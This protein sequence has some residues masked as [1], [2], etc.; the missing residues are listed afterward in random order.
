MLKHYLTKQLSLVLQLLML[1]ACSSFATIVLWNSQFTVSAN[2]T[3]DWRRSGL[4]GIGITSI[5][6]DVNNT[7]YL[8]AASRD[9]IGV[10]ISSNSGESWTN[11]DE[12]LTN[13]NI[14]T[15]ASCTSGWL[16]AGS[17]GDGVYRRTSNT[18]WSRVSNGVTE[19]FITALS[20]GANSTVFVAT[21][22]QGVFRSTNHGESW[23]SISQGLGQLEILSLYYADGWLLVGTK[24]GLFAQQ[25]SSSGWQLI[26][27]ADRT[28]YALFTTNDY[29]WAGTDQGVYRTPLANLMNWA[30][31]GVLPQ[32]V[33]AL[34]ADSDTSLYAGTRDAGVYQ[35]SSEEWQP[36]NTNLLVTRIYALRLGTDETSKLFAGTIDGI[37][38][39]QVQR[40]P[41]P[42]AP[43]T[44]NQTPTSTP[45]PTPT[46]TPG[47][48]YLRLRSEPTGVIA[49]GETLT[50]II[51]YGAIE[52]ATTGYELQSV[53]ITNVIPAAVNL[54]PASLPT[55]SPQ[56]LVTTT[57]DKAGSVITWT[58]L[59]PVPDGAHGAISYQVQR[60]TVTP[61]LMPTAPS[62]P[63]ALQ[64][65]KSGPAMA[66]PDAFIV[67]TLS[68]TNPS[69]MIAT[70]VIMTDR[71]PL[72]AQYVT[73]G[74]REGEIVKWMDIGNLAPAEPVSRVFVVTAAQTITNSDYGVQADGIPVITGTK[75][76]VTIIGNSVTS[77]GATNLIINQGASM[78]WLYNGQTGRITSG[79]TY[80]PVTIL[81]LP[82]MAKAK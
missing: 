38:S 74:V 47:I 63:K 69:N 53:V 31:I 16:F 18:P 46:S 67:Y 10:R 14:E 76:I 32:I 36:F 39:S 17:W 5:I 25:D 71:I 33:Y 52:H 40:T 55:N 15:I 79:P 59:T 26:G 41:T 82:F 3:E 23:Q 4:N 20:C 66:T 43:P 50:Y 27:L 70:N 65:T 73:G 28:I 9:V 21:A 81:Y 6:N 58:F 29:W 44:V 62:Q 37:W 22:S 49:Y 77:P 30:S 2:G 72:H 54:I 60:P 80:N 68:V 24:Q 51:E 8:Y 78:R 11:Y 75:S 19:Q 64:I 56:L 45:T 7:A 12:G 35:L 34:T 1:L 42:I 48:G 13:A 57:G 61:T